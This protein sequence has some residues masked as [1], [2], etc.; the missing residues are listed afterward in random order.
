LICPAL[1]VVFA[2]LLSVLVPRSVPPL[3]VIGPFTVRVPVPEK[4]PPAKL[5]V[6]EAPDETAALAET[7]PPVT[8]MVPAPVKLAPRIEVMRAAAELERRARAR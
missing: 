5:K 3:Q 2:V 7:V 8:E 6:V 1:H 4:V